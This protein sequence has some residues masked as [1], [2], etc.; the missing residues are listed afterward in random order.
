MNEQWARSLFMDYLYDEIDPGDKQKLEQFLKEHPSLQKEL[1]SLRQTHL[2]LQQMPDIEPAPRLLVVESQRRSLRQWLQD[3]KSLLPRT[4]VGKTG[5]ALALSLLLL[6]F[7]GSVARVH[8]AFT[9]NGA[10]ISLGYTPVINE[11]LTQQE[12]QALIQ[13]NQQEQA[14]LLSD[15]TQ[16]MNQQYDAQLQQVIQYLEQQRLEDLQL[17][18]QNMEQLQHH[19]YYRWNQTNRFLDEVLQTV[20]YTN[21]NEP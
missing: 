12:A 4:A 5:F 6:F 14:A 11:G 8:I 7:A 21:T 15:Y 18:G 1:H 3:A 17:I 13:Q 2:K 19:T 20:R 16:A 10:S 9:D